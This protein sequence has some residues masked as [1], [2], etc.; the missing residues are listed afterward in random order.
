MGLI[1]ALLAVLLAEVGERALMLRSAGGRGAFVAI[2]AGLIAAG[3]VAGA[4]IA[5]RM[6]LP[7]RDL[8]LGVAL[9][10]AGV[11]QLR[12]VKPISGSWRGALQ[13]WQGGTLLLAFALAARFEAWSVA[14]GIA[15]GLLA[16]LVLTH[17][18]TTAGLALPLLRR[19]AAGVLLI[20]G[21]VC[22]LGALRLI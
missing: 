20:A 11:T 6:T 18:A 2:V 1:P 8:M 12:R 17:A 3:T 4:L 13:F 22:A 21:A 5:P 10:L 16:A 15:G 19:V 7:A 14:P 9:L